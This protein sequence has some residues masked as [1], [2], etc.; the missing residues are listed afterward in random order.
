MLV[1]QT[2]TYPNITGLNLF[3]MD[4]DLYIY[5][6]EDE[7]AEDSITITVNDNVYPHIVWSS[8]GQGSSEKMKYTI[9]LRYDDV[10]FM[11]RKPNLTISLTVKNLELISL[12]GSSTAYIEDVVISD[13]LRID[14]R[15][16]STFRLRNGGR[17][18]ANHISAVLSGASK[19]ELEGQCKTLDLVLS[20]SSRASGFGMVCDDL[21]AKLSGAS[22]AEFT[23]LNTLSA[24]L[25]GSSILRYDGN[26][27]IGYS[28]ITGSSRL[29]RR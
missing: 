13:D 11:H 10:S 14:L 6:S 12:G 24:T 25:S 9:S 29:E 7:N 1:T 23:V 19:M 22:K 28:N 21:D 27:T 4:C 2:F 17:I 18:E 16:A 26:P 3:D 5:I 8:L 15:S 20:G